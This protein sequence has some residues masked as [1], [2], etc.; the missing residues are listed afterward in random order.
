MCSAGLKAIWE[1]PPSPTGKARLLSQF[2]RTVHEHDAP[3]SRRGEHREGSV[4]NEGRERA[5]IR[6]WL[7]RMV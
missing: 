7:G 6:L 2:F 4:S 5:M 1:M 3:Q